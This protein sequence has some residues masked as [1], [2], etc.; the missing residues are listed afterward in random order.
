MTDSEDVLTLTAPLKMLPDGTK[1][2]LNTRP[3]PIWLT[4]YRTLPFPVERTI[5]TN[6]KC[7]CVLLRQASGNVVVVN[8]ETEV[9]VDGTAKQLRKLLGRAL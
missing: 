9:Y 5:K 6:P 7:G 3:N 2:K 4:V 1:V 8:E